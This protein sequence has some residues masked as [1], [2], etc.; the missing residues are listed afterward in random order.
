MIQRGITKVIL[1]GLYM[2]L[3]QQKSGTYE[4]LYE[5]LCHLA[6]SFRAW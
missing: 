5:S 6:S 1:R 3:W 2:I 4:D